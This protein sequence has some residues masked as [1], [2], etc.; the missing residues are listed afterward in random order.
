MN[1]KEIAENYEKSNMQILVVKPE[2][3][4]NNNTNGVAGSF[5][6]YIRHVPVN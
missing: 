5:C 2:I 3:R 4:N 1:P 6:R